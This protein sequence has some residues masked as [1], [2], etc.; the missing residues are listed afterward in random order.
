M[1][2][3]GKWVE[4]EIIMLSEHK[5]TQKDKNHIFLSHAVSR[6]YAYVIIYMCIYGIYTIIVNGGPWGD[7]WEE[8]EEKRMMRDE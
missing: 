5:Q 7:K 1:P 2:F 6:L 4:V 3:A 8:G